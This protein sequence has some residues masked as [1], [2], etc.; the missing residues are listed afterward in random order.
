MDQVT[1]KRRIPNYVDGKSTTHTIN[2]MEDLDNIDWILNFK[3]QMG[4]RLIER[5]GYVEQPDLLFAVYE[6]KYENI[7]LFEKVVIG[8]IYGDQDNYVLGLPVYEE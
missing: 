6:K 2:R 4:F 5:G 1:I 7:S 3:K 8:Y